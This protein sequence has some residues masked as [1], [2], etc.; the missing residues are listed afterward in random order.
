MTEIKIGIIGTDTSHSI[1]FTQLLH[2][3][4]QPYHVP[5]GRVVAAYP[6]G[7]ADFPLSANRVE[8]YMDRLETEFAVKRT[9]SMEE[10]VSY[11]DAILLLSADGR[12]HVEQFK[13]ICSYG[14]PVYIDKPLALNRVDAAEI[15]RLADEVKLPIMS[16]S[17]L[18][19]AEQLIPYLA[20]GNSTDI[21]GATVFGPLVIEPTQSYYYWYGIHSIELLYS[22]MGAGCREVNVT[23]KN[24]KEVIEGI[25]KDGRCGIVM[26]ELNATA[27]FR[28][29]IHSADRTEM[30]EITS[31]GKPFYASLLEQIMNM[32]REGCP[33][34]T[35][36]ETQEII[37]FIEAAECS[38]MSGCRTVVE[39]E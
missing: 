3:T 20:D 14:K 11:V 39:T 10:L 22:I 32:F 23:V 33:T 1:A 37:R 38:R 28:A 21:Q 7:S 27:S 17:A 18:R 19:Y 2:D 26:L 6:G 34:L 30:I 16:S 4:S 15:F 5:G 29:A 12:V 9:S 31:H 36:D 8:I 24:D 35:P 25:W 13:Q